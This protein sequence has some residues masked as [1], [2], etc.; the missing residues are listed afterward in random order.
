MPNISIQIS[1][2][3]V[4]WYGAV[5]ATGALLVSSYNAWIDRPRINIKYQKGMLIINAAPLYSEDLTYFVIT[6]TN[7]GRR[8]VA[9]GNVGIMLFKGGALLLSD[10]LN[11]VNRVLTEEQ[12][13][14]QITTEQDLLDFS[15]V[16]YIVVYDKAGREY[17]K[18]FNRL[19][20]LKK[21]LFLI[22]NYGKN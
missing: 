15:K 9:I 5:V 21:L 16:Y 11:G 10:S 3:T 17:R 19:P 12:P 8:P 18:Y 20:S 7:A 6:I 1:A 22:K 4:A 14:T 2:N 13:E